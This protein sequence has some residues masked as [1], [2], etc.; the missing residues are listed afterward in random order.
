MRS[1]AVTH[2]RDV[3]LADRSYPDWDQLAFASRG[4][5]TVTTR[6]GVWV[7]PPHRAVWIPAGEV[8][9]VRTSGRV[10]LRTLYLRPELGAG[11][12]PRVCTALHVTPLVRELV[13]HAASRNTLRRDVAADCNLAAVIVD[14]LVISPLE[15]L[16]LPMPRDDRARSAATEIQDDPARPLSIVA[17]RAGASLRTLERLFLR[18]TAMPLGRWRRRARLIHALKLLAEGVPVAG[19]ASEV[20]YETTSAF[21]AVFRRELGTTPGRY[22]ADGSAGAPTE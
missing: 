4:V 14:Q 2:P 9:G 18:D 12:L 15:P 6:A 7:V 13:L 17:R 22:F 16:Q 5:M 1:Y 19:V 11:R 20:G 8:H 21:I 3:G 10:A